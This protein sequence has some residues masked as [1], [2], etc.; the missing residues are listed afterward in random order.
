[1]ST[2]QLC[3]LFV[4]APLLLALPVAA[5]SDNLAVNGGFES[6]NELKDDHP[7]VRKLSDEGWIFDT[8]FLLPTGWGLNPYGK[9]GVYRLIADRR[10]AHSGDNCVFTTGDLGARYLAVV[11]GDRVTLRFW[12]KASEEQP[13]YGIL[14]AYGKDTEGKVVSMGDSLRFRAT[15]GPEWQECVGTITIPEKIG[16]TIVSSV[17]PCLRSA[18]GAWFDDVTVTINEKGLKEEASVATR[19]PAPAA[20]QDPLNGSFENWGALEKPPA[21]WELANGEFPEQWEIDARPQGKGKVRR[22]LNPENDRARFGSYHLLLD[23]R[24]LSKHVFSAAVGQSY[25]ISCRAKGREGRIIGRL[26]YLHRT[27]PGGKDVTDCEDAL[28]VD[29][30]TGD[31][32]KDYSVVVKTVESNWR[33]DLEG[34]AVQIDNLRVEKTAASEAAKDELPSAFLSIPLLDRE[35]ALDGSGTAE[36]WQ[37]SVGMKNGFMDIESQTMVSRQ[38]EFAVTASRERLYILAISHPSGTGFKST[39]KER[40]GPVWGDDSLEICVNPDPKEGATSNVYQIIINPDGVVYDSIHERATAQ[41]QANW[42]CRGLEVKTGRREGRIIWEVAIPL[43]EVDVKPGTPFGLNLA[44]DLKNPAEN[45]N[46]SGKAYRDYPSMPRCALVKGAPAVRWESTGDFKTGALRLSASLRNGGASEN[47]C[48]ATLACGAQQETKVVRLPP[49]STQTVALD[50]GEQTMK[51]GNLVLTVKDASGQTIDLQAVRFDAGRFKKERADAGDAPPWRLDFYPVQKKI[52][53]VLLD[54]AV[55]EQAGAPYG[56]VEFTVYR[57]D[58]LVQR[59]SINPTPVRSGVSHATV[60]FTPDREGPY[61][62]VVVI[63]DRQGRCVDSFTETVESK[64][65]P[66]LGNALGKDRVVIPPFTPLQIDGNTVGCWGRQYELGQDGLVKGLVSQNEKVLSG[67]MRFVLDDGTQTHEGVAGTG[68]KFDEKAVDQV[69]FQGVTDVANLQVK[70]SGCME[71]DGMIRYEMELAPRKVSEI[72]RFS[73]EIPFR[74]MRYFHWSVCMRSPGSG[75]AMFAPKEGEYRDPNVAMW[76]P[77]AA[78]TDKGPISRYLPREDGVVWSSKGIKNRGVYG[79]FIPYLMLGNEKYGFCWFANSDRGWSHDESSTCFE[80]VRKGEEVV[81]RVNFIAVP[82]T[83]K[84]PRKIVFGIMATPTRPRITGGN[85]AFPV[86]IGEL[87]FLKRAMWVEYEDAFLAAKLHDLRRAGGQIKHIYMANNSIPINDDVVKHCK[88]EWILRDAALFSCL[89]GLPTMRYGLEPAN[90]LVYWNCAMSSLVDYEVWSIAQGLKQ[91]CMDGMYMDNSYP[92][93]C[94]D[95]QHENCGYLREDGNLQAQFHL[96]ETRDLI[97]RVAVL[98]HQLKLPAPHWSIH[99][100]STMLVPCFSFGELYIDGEWDYEHKN[101]FDVFGQPYLE[102]FGIGAWGGNQG[103]LSKVNSQEIKPTRAYLAAM[104]LYDIWKWPAYCNF[105]VAAKFMNLD[106]SFGV[107]APDCRFVGYWQEDGRAVSG[108]P[109]A[110]KS[111]Y[112]VRPGKGALIYVSNFNP[113]KQD[114]NCRLD[115]KKWDLGECKV[116][117]AETEQEIPLTSG[118]LPLAVEGHDFRLIRVEKK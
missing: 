47:T 57:G 59:Q 46:L 91:G 12:A 77:S 76:Q 33:I 22:V 58:A 65:M 101:F 92:Q 15:A 114:V 56:S 11:S 105:A 9:T 82:T 110:V 115:F 81:L 80:L 25:T 42:N 63:S 31:S 83:L 54:A 116:V 78:Y 62:V 94:A 49:N 40:D 53:V 66:W 50:A 45:A 30:T 100:T 28:V 48:Q 61:R 1:M 70:L 35:L 17:V 44:R 88:S 74:D 103:W 2:R 19:M 89:G 52:D 99:M 72:R 109:V 95:L 112:Y 34:A 18:R 113:K 6:V 97:K 79:N 14:S 90:Y 38:T 87:G 5:E 73:L 10:I 107:T 117:D 20:N 26:R 24:I 85:A 13:V 75:W 60:P 108:L 71:Y 106:K 41:T 93:A 16:N 36:K 3:L 118:T 68:W 86:S 64:A 7:T 51:T 37:E 4:A 43:A 8:P 84:E 104:N 55:R 32:W 96:F 111:S 98:A 21:G 102:G 67:G 39:I 29:E 69:S 27:G 23:G